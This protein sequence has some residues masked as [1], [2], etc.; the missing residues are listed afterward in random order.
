MYNA[1]ACVSI[2]HLSTWPYEAANVIHYS[3]AMWKQM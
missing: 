2:H 3:G 1:L